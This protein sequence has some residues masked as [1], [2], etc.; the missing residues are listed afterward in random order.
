MGSEIVNLAP[1]AKRGHYMA[2][3]K[4]LKNPVHQKSGELGENGAITFFP[5]LYRAR[6]GFFHVGEKN[7][8]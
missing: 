3:S 2:I 5:G 4:R 1:F 7:Q 8:G 6:I